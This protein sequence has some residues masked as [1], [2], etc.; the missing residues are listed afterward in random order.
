MLPG[1]EPSALGYTPTYMSAARL[2]ARAVPLALAAAFSP[3][4]GA[5]PPPNG[6]EKVAQPEKQ[7]VL[8]ETVVSP[9]EDVQLAHDFQTAN[10][11]LLGGK[12]REALTAFDRLLRL[13]P[14]G[15]TAAPSMVNGGIALEELGERDAALERYKQAFEKFPNA[16]TAK[17]AL[18][19]T[20]RL[21]SRLEKWADLQA[22]SDKLLVLS[23]LKLLESIEAR[24]FRALALAEQGKIEEAAKD[25]DKALTAA[26]EAKLGLT[27][28]PPIEMAPAYFAQGEVRRLKSEAIVFTPLPPNF[29]DV[30]E[31]RCQ[32]LLD[33]Q[34]AYTD[35]LRARDA[36]WS[37]MAG[38][39]IGQLYQVLH[40]DVMKIPTPA[41]AKTLKDKQLFEGVMR[42]RYRVLLE[43]G[44]KMMAGTVQ[45]AQRT[46]EAST[47]VGRAEKAKEELERALADEKAALAK[48]PFTEDELKAAMEK[49]KKG[50]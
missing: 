35:A 11:Q 42:L 16:D 38:Y 34:N 37:A 18:Q 19:R 29:T 48:M 33:A 32:G 44:L 7:V 17:I 20:I 15:P 43:K 6:P 47:W 3:G 46:H 26:E 36:H 41:K 23:D 27:E 13:A 49:L 30:L 28:K 40:A 9:F 39:R 21:Q 2:L 14:D 5:A 4:C 25:V 8:P 31:K 12:A 45:M 1:A 24:G 50:P 10:A 22:W